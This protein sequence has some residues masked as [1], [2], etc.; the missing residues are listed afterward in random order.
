MRPPFPVADVEQLAEKV[1]TAQKV[2][3]G[4]GHNLMIHPVQM[5]RLDEVGF[6]QRQR[7]LAI[8][9]G[10]GFQGTDL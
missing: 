5:I 1:E 2:P 9:D 4:Q 6:D 3:C 10:S 8:I 7:I